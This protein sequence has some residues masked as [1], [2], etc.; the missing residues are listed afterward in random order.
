MYFLNFSTLKTYIIL[1]FSSYTKIWNINAR[2]HKK[3]TNIYKC[4]FF[5]CGL[6]QAGYC[7]RATVG[8]QV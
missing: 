5:L 1:V 6:M 7:G 2:V 3:V 8:L 4:M